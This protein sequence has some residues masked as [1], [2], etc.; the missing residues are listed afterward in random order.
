MNDNRQIAINSLLNLTN[1][2]KK[3]SDGTY[4]GKE[5]YNDLKKLVQLELKK[6]YKLNNYK[7]E[8]QNKND[9][10][11]VDTTGTKALASAEAVSA[12]P[13]SESDVYEIIDLNNSNA[14]SELNKAI[15]E[16]FEKN[17]SKIQDIGDYI[18]LD[19]KKYKLDDIKCDFN[20][21]YKYTHNKVDKTAD[22]TETNPS[23]EIYYKPE[24]VLNENPKELAKIINDLKE[25]EKIFK[26]DNYS[27]LDDMVKIDFYK[28]LI[29]NIE[30]INKIFKKNDPDITNELIQ[31]IEKKLKSLYDLKEP[32]KDKN[33]NKFKEEF[34]TF[35]TKKT[36]IY[37]GTMGYTED[38]INNI[39]KFL[40]NI[41]KNI[42]D[43]KLSEN[44]KS[45]KNIRNPLIN[46]HVKNIKNSDLNDDKIIQKLK[47]GTDILLLYFIL[48]KLNNQI[49]MKGGAVPPA[50]LDNISQ[51]NTIDDNIDT[52]ML[53]LDI[54]KN[55]VKN[56]KSISLKW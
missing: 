48:I 55:I 44:L 26:V 18:E 37:G 3:L 56:F 10:F 42:D 2:Y 13:E 19:K 34:E 23:F 47:E 33:K 8:K 6:K 30:K 4:I 43:K 7:L 17:S 54:Y 45:I 25:L 35:I 24:L 9:I 41:R 31:N 5:L 28:E 53:L 29:T 51:K 22:K 32:R 16:Y 36:S 49:N 27:S 14:Y 52:N 39:I 50:K 38:D 21:I 11:N 1:N 12:A 15:S 40:Q 46:K 20:T